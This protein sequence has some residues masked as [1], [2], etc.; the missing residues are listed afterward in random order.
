MIKKL[1]WLPSGYLFLDHSALNVNL[2]P[3]RM[4]KLPIWSFLLETKDGPIIV[5]TGMPDSFIGNPDYFN[6][7]PLEGQFL[8][9]MEQKD[10]I[11]NLIKKAGYE[12][13]DIQAVINSHLHMDHAGG[14]PYFPNTPIY[15]QKAELEAAINNPN[16]APPE[17]I[18]PDLQYHPIEGDYEVAPGIQLLFTPGHSPGHQSV[19]VTTEKSGPVLLT[20]DLA[21]T[22]ENYEHLVPFASSDFELAIQ[23]IR[24][25]KQ[26]AQ[27]IRPSL[28][29]FGHDLEQAKQ[30]RTFPEFL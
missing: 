22:Q 24:N 18:Q 29:F 17:C 30:Q 23:S 28:I 13:S 4:V 27:E 11:R 1:H 3:G 19:L 10:H 15:V 9:E 12:I 26:K 25:M 14:N 21:Y 6:G 16:Y 2:S 5:D 20:I 7:T 8:P